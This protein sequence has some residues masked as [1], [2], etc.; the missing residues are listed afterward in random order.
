MRSSHVALLIF[1][2]ATSA[3]PAQSGPPSVRIIQASACDTVITIERLRHLPA[4]TVE[5]K[6]H[7]GQSATYTGALLMDVIGAGC[8]SIPAAEKRERIGMAVRV[9]AQDG[10]HAIIALMEA[11]TSFREHPVLLTWAR[12]GKA[13]DEHDGPL[14]LIIPDDLRH[15]RDVRGVK[16]LSIVTP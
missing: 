9:D 1:A 16:Q 10:Y 6:G 3:A 13:L 11:D 4:H 8:P 14:Q 12:N 15:A 2:M 5:I 7:D